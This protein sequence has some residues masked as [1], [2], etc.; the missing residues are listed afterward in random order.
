M[1]RGPTASR[2]AR[3]SFKALDPS[4]AP[5]VYEQT[6][7]IWR[8]AGHRSSC[9]A[10]DVDPLSTRFIASAA[11]RRQYRY[12]GDVRSPR[13]NPALIGPYY[14][15]HL[16]LELQIGGGTSRGKRLVQRSWIEALLRKPA[17]YL[18]ATTGPR[19]TR[20]EPARTAICERGTP[21]DSYRRSL[22]ELGA[23]V[24]AAM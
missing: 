7:D 12:R 20:W 5:Q 21:L 2:C 10:R 9:C 23:W 3:S 4:I 17:I 19:P 24:D 13:T 8:R 14:R 1:D 15:H 22:A 16:S 11:Q 6:L 18:S